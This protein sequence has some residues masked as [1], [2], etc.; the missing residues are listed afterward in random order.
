ME[1]ENRHLNLQIQTKNQ[2]LVT[3]NRQLAELL[4]Q[5]QKQINLGE[6]SLSIVRE[7]L[8]YVPLPIIAV[9]DENMVVFINSSAEQVIPESRLDLGCQIEYLIPDVGIGME[10]ISEGL[11]FPVD[12]YQKP[13]HAQWKNTGEKNK[14]SGK[15]VML[16]DDHMRH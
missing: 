16:I 7:V 8:Q 5:K 6:L 12:V 1:D 2:E 4:Q 14:P 10:N 11:W 3:A 15:I 9:D 13:F